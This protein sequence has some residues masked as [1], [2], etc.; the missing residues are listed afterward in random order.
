MAESHRVFLALGTNLGDRWDN[1]RQA[2]RALAALMVVETIS[3][4]YETAPWGIEDQPE[5][6]NICL[7]ATTT[8]APHPL[9]AAIKDLEVK[10]GRRPGPRW[11]PRL[12]DIDILFYDDL[13]LQSEG[14]TIPHPHLAERVFVLAPLADIAPQFRHPQTG[15]S[16]AQMAKAVDMT[17]VRKLD[18]PLFE[19]ER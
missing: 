17:S 19:E 7:S 4:V 12:I 9:L 18:V 1:L 6:L 10:L 15:L 16:V 2:V 11:G 8:L 5:F 14:L 13:I 3:P